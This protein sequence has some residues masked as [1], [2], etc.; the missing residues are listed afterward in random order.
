MTVEEF[1]QTLKN[2]KITEIYKTLMPCLSMVPKLLWTLVTIGHVQFILVAFKPFWTGPEKS[3]LNPTK[4]IWTRPNQFGQS[5][6][7]LDLYKDKA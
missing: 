3:N 1:Y 4:M 2:I 5:K 6:I 7:I